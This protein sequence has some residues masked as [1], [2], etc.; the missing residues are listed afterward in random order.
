MRMRQ[1]SALAILAIA[2]VSLCMAVLAKTTEPAVAA[3]SRGGGAVYFRRV[4][5]L[6][7]G[8]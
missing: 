7:A 6:S 5:Q 4:L 1:I 8:G 3:Q 2:M